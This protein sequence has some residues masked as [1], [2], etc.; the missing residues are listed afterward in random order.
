MPK[1]LIHVLWALML[2]PYL[3]ARTHYTCNILYIQQSTHAHARIPWT[4]THS[5][6]HDVDTD[7]YTHTRIHARLHTYR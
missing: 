2:P 5:H 6:K 1:P 7:I 4:D 3:H